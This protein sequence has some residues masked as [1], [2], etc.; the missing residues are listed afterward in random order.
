MAGSATYYSNRVL[1][2]FKNY[3]L[4]ELLDYFDNKLGYNTMPWNL[5]HIYYKR[6]VT[7]IIK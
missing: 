6:I 5:E 3:I 7:I 4:Q 2:Y 1:I